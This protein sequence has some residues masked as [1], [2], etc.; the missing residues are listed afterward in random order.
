MKNN[1][2]K[3]KEYHNSFGQIVSILEFIESK[4]DSVEV[5]EAKMAVENVLKK[6]IEKMRIKSEE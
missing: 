6:L 2:S 1:L 5:N 4:S 3:Y